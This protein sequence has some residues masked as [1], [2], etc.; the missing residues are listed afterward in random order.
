MG[1]RIDLFTGS[2]H[3]ASLSLPLA[4]ALAVTTAAASPQEVELH[5]DKPVTLE[6][7]ADDPVLEGHGPYCSAWYLSDF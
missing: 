4:L 5:L 2:N 6:I 1:L 7:F 3:M